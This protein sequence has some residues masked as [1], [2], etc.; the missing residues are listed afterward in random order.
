VICQNSIYVAM[1]LLCGLVLIPMGSLPVI[2]IRTA[3]TNAI[4]IDSILTPLPTGDMTHIVNA[5]I[6][7]THIISTSSTTMDMTCLCT[8]ALHL[9]AKQISLNP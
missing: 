9:Q 3:Y 1:V 7:V 6:S 8:L 4:T 2:A 5:I